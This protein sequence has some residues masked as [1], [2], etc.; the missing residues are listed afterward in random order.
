MGLDG[1]PL[2]E[3]VRWAMETAGLPFAEF[4][5]RFTQSL[6][7]GEQRKAA[8]AGVLALR[9]RILLLDEPTAG[10]DPPARRAL[11]AT[12]QEL[13]SQEG[14]TLVVATHAMED[15]LALADR[16]VALQAGRIAAD[17]SPRL[18]FGAPDL[19][20]G[21]GLRLPEIVGLM[22]RLRAAGA[23]VA[24]DGMTVEEAAAGLFQAAL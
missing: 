8:L 4:K 3:R 22:H 16:V 11:L 6:S 7:G 19:W 21:L 12:L 14:M 20:H 15:V 18:L 1:D 5:D 17:G 9:P 24:T 23:G 13:N 10:L 2:R